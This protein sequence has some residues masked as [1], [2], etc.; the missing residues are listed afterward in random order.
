M[1]LPQPLDSRALARI[2]I[3]L[4]PLSPIGIA[5]LHSAVSPA[6]ASWP[7]NVVNHALVERIGQMEERH[8]IDPF[9]KDFLQSFEITSIIDAFF[10]TVEVKGKL[11][12]KL[13]NKVRDFLSHDRETLG[14]SSGPPSVFWE[15]TQR[16]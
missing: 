2:A 5:I 11:R 6:P 10:S 3:G 13:K 16:C 7:A 1:S 14:F 15:Q 9:Y 4:P 8:A 12:Q